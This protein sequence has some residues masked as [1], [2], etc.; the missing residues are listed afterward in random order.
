MSHHVF[1]QILLLPLSHIGF[2]GKDPLLLLTEELHQRRGI[3][4]GNTGGLRVA[5]ALVG[6][7][8]KHLRLVREPWWPSPI[9]RAPVLE[10]DYCPSHFSLEF[11]SEARDFHLRSQNSLPWPRIGDFFDQERNL[12]Y[13][14][15][16]LL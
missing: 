5:L 14:I 8:W 3:V 12:P 9:C 10:E 4:F 1:L 11:D 7:M 13:P 16:M 6:E 2:Q 15:L